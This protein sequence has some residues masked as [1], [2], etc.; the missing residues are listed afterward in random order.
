MAAIFGRIDE[1]EE[2][3]ED[4]SQYVE[5]LQ[6]FFEAN[7]VTED[8]KKRSILLSVMGPS[9]YKLLRS[10]V[11]PAKPGEK[12]Y[13]ELVAAMKQHHNPVPS[14]IVQ[15]YKF[16]SRFRREGESVATFVSELR[17]LAEFCN[18]G[19]T[20]DN[21]LRD[22][23]VCGINA[24][25]IQRRLLSEEKLTFKKA[26]DTAVALETA[27]ANARM[28]Q[29]APQQSVGMEGRAAE[30]VH[31]MQSKNEP[32]VGEA[33][34]YRCGRS[35]HTAL[36][37]RFKT[38]K[39]H[40]CGKVGHLVRVCRSKSSLK[41]AKT[42]ATRA[43]GIQVLQA[44]QGAEDQLPHAQTPGEEYALFHLGSEPGT[45]LRVWVKINQQPLEME[46]D[47]GASLSVVS[48]TTF[49][50]YWPEKELS[51]AIVELRTYTG[52]RVKVKGRLEV[53]ISY[54]SQQAN[55]TLLVI[56]GD[57]PSLLGRDWLQLFRLNWSEILQLQQGP[58]FQALLRQHQSVFQEGLGTMKGVTAKLYVDRDAKPRFHKARSV[59]FAMRQKVDEELQRLQELGIIEPVQFAEWAAPIVPILKADKKTVRICGDYKLTVNQACKLDNYPIPRVEELLATLGGGKLFTK[60]DLSQAYQQL[61]LD[62]ESKR[63]VVINTQRGLF[64]YNRL[65][66]GV[67][68]APGIFQRA[69]ENLL[70]GIPH[71]LVFMDDILVSGASEEEH[72]STLA[73]VLAR[74][75]DAG[76]RLKQQKCVFMVNSIT[77]LGHK[78]DAQGLH[79]LE[80]K[81][82]AV[83]EAPI[84]QNVTELKAYL[85]LLTYYGRFLPNRAEVLAPLYKLL[86]TKVPWK[87]SSKE[88]GA[89]QA[90]KR[91][92]LS[93]PCLAHFDS[94][95]EVVLSC[96]ASA[97]GI[98]AVLSQRQE[99][100]SE[101]PVGFASRTLTPAE[102]N[103]S[104]LEKEGLACVF[105]V[106]HFHCY[107]YGRHFHLCTDHQPLLSLFSE[108]RAVPPQASARIQRWAL[109]LS[110][111]EYTLVFKRTMDH[112]N[113]DALSRLPLPEHPTSV[114]LPAETIFLMEFLK[115]S[116]VT[117]S[118]I[119]AW[120]RKDPL[121]ARV[122]K[123]VKEGWPDV[124]AE[125]LQ[126]FTA[127][128]LELS[129]QDDCLLWGNRVVV[130]PPGRFPILCELHEGHPGTSR[131]KGL[132]RGVVWWP[133][134]DREIEEKVKSCHDCQS[135]R[136]TPPAAPLHPWEYPS[137]PWAR[138]HID[139][140]GPFLGHMFMV[141][142]D[143][144]SKWLEV[145]TLQATTSA[146]IVGHL[147]T[148][149]ARFGIPEMV[150][151][152]NAPY[153]VSQEFEEF[154]RLNGCKH[155]TSAPYHPASNGLAERAVQ[156]FKAGV[157]RMKTGSLQ[158]KVARFLFAYRRTPH[159][160][161]G[162]SPAELLLG[163][164]LRSR[165]DL[166]H[167][168]A[169]GRVQLKQHKQKE[170]HD[171]RVANRT[172][173]PGDLV[174]CRNFG[175]GPAWL[176]GRILEAT[177]P[178]SFR[179]E[180]E[181]GRT[182]WRRHQDHI[183]KKY[184]EDPH[185][186]TSES[187]SIPLLDPASGTSLTPEG[188]ELEETPTKVSAV[189]RPSLSPVG[190]PPDMDHAPMAA[191]EQAEVTSP[192]SSTA[193]RYPE[194]IR[195]PPQKYGFD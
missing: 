25:H 65:P 73:K 82:K 16:N 141:I 8:A 33:R 74:L 179:I 54:Q 48:E 112:A 180:L 28:L 92:L 135:T 101:K 178:V 18:F 81:V 72:L 37:C 95:K 94:S 63:Y 187:L 98:G 131:M 163:R 121:L 111:Y 75:E 151:S 35:D 166:L 108:K 79:P 133:G 64:Q 46:V 159:T 142:I 123:Y 188:Q 185:T 137:R 191:N 120:T 194:R 86:Q 132:A 114:P 53:D 36:D 91:L 58:S 56:E 89:F 130:P 57:G 14:E 3:K 66:F 5:R 2:D 126:P 139:L 193:R 62:A 146:A 150:V 52:E 145:I 168:D 67:S 175:Q 129:V 172:L 30:P 136:P 22:R 134:M 140:A 31:R 181:D 70:Q 87:W 29:S 158:D 11:S 32:K 164:N 109:T 23:L 50:R 186:A 182:V 103:Y 128:R 162:N 144:Y 76:V 93:A 147:R 80:S 68:S 49:Q 4:W 43:P 41:S 127:R 156:V 143:A 115:S 171:R 122:L 189:A 40:G 21:M 173:E 117:A 176:P 107:L 83:Q 154:L 124:S 169:A 24:D 59:P 13:E 152:D 165:L 177:G 118:H 184:D 161:T 27:A 78:I 192:V 153:F 138:V 157:K 47:T 170:I 9:S 116:P 155:V 125:E 42:D 77:F 84:P 10:L 190:Y 102:R 85:G 97:Y 195:R 105:G 90:S 51:E 119:R 167:P 19:A 113:A 1:F 61:L 26:M 17:S 110:M 106:K 44:E 45:P 104:Q 183:R 34:C 7:G 100:G 12:S 148:T 69:M 149:F 39:C 71:V 6:H 38:A 15:R 88:A 99:D 96:D 174:Y 60:L 20:L 160:T 55:G